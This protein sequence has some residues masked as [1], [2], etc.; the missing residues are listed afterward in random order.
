MIPPM[1]GGV[2][3]AEM[4]EDNVGGDALDRELATRIADGA[5]AG[6]GSRAPSSQGVQ[7]YSRSGQHHRF[8]YLLEVAGIGR[9]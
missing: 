6:R 9:P 2:L 3:P 4:R 8:G 5:D 1:T 7:E